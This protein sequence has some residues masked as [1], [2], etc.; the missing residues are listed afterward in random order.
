MEAGVNL[1]PRNNRSLSPLEELATIT[2]TAFQFGNTEYSQ[3]AISDR[4]L[5]IARLMVEAG[6]DPREQI[7]DLPS[8]LDL[9]NDAGDTEM[10]EIFTESP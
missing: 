7:N 10:A 6:V 2:N 9:A 3:Y 8:A 5:E 4:R 1:T